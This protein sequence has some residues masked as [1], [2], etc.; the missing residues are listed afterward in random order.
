MRSWFASSAA[1]RRSRRRA[2]ARSSKGITVAIAQENTLR[3]V[4]FLQRGLEAE[5]RCFDTEKPS[6]IDPGDDVPA[7]ERGNES[8]RSPRHAP[9][10]GQ[11]DYAHDIQNNG[12]SHCSGHPPLMMSHVQES[13]VRAEK[14]VGNLA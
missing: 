13:C 4:N 2:T 11:A 1:P 3:A 5:N 8:E 10:Q 6:R 12:N 14:G 9:Q 7:D